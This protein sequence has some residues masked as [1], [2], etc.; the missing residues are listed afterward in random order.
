MESIRILTGLAEAPVLI[1]VYPEMCI[2]FCELQP[3]ATGISHE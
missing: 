2:Y 3:C 1:A